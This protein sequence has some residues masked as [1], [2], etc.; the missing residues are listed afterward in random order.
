MAQISIA[1]LC[2]FIHKVT[3]Y[4]LGLFKK[5]WKQTIYYR[6]NLS[7]NI[8]D[9]GLNIYFG[10]GPVKKLIPINFEI[11]CIVKVFYVLNIIKMTSSQKDQLKQIV[12]TF[13]RILEV[14]KFFM[15]LLTQPYNFM[16]LI[17]TP[18]SKVKMKGR[19]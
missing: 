3:K 14:I 10:Q 8:R 18:C 4:T 12:F 19:K 2:I 6:D 7:S 16:M 13:V 17:C 9:Y 5:S 15:K 11:H 1:L